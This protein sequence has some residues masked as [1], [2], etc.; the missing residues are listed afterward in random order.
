M[1]ESSQTN[2]GI[3]GIAGFLYAL[4]LHQK[5]PTENKVSIMAQ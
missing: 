3:E 4:V 5:Q 1:L 2:R